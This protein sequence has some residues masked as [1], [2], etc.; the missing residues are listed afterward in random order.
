MNDFDTYT[1]SYERHRQA[2]SRANTLNKAIVLDALAAA[3]ITEVTVTFDGEGDSGQIDSITACLGETPKALPAPTEDVPS[4]PVT[5]PAAP[6]PLPATPVTLH[7][8]QWHSDE[9]GVHDTTLQDAIETLC[10]DYLAQEQGGWENNEGAYG[11]FRFDVAARTIQ[12]DF[13]ARII[14]AVHSY[15]EF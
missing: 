8:A 10:Y 14:D 3:N 13:H 2:T 15:H 6:V 7:Q 9:L 1:A 11:A 12:L 5:S 4:L